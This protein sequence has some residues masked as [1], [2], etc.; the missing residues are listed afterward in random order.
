M[1]ED[2][3]AQR[4]L[5]RLQDLLT[6][7]HEEL[8]TELKDW[9]DLSSESHRAN[10]AQAIL[11]L[12]NHGGGFILLGFTKKDGS[13]APAE[14]RPSD[15]NPYSQDS[16][17]AIVQRYAEPPF[18]C[19]VHHVAHPETGQPFPIV[20]VPG[21]HKIPIRAKR[22]GPNQ[23]HVRQNTYYIRRPGPQSG[24]P[25]SGR[26][27][28][29]L[30]GRC[31][32]A[33]RD[34]LLDRIREILQASG[35]IPRPK[36][37]EEKRSEFENW[38]E[39][40]IARFNSLVAQKLSDE[41]PSRYS[42]GIWHVAYSILGDLRS[43]SL[44]DLLEILRK[45]KG[46]ETGWPPW[47]VPTRAEIAPYPYE[48]VAECWLRETRSDLLFGE[49]RSDNFRFTA[50]SDFWRASPKGMMFLLRGYQED[51]SPH[52][53]PGTIVDV[54]LPIWRTGECLLHAQRLAIALGGRSTSVVIRVTWRGLLGRTLASW[55]NPRRMLLLPESPSRQDS[56]TSEITVSTEQISATLPEIV[57]AL[58]APL[59][60]VFG[61]FVMPSNVIQEELSNM[62]SRVSYTPS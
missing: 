20:V 47:W 26:E 38:I 27:W 33:A 55:A 9:L 32:M 58:T 12:A 56:V 42:K 36:F 22:D 46:H 17:N 21:G 50:D 35:G 6:R 54:T 62:R 57:R 23:E 15:L 34:D 37:A 43:P 24:P 59:Y 19:D 53:E 61:F 10:L 30:I 39:T 45:V 3:Q 5:K 51:G 49:P 13:W 7:A 18:H 4:S 40:S 14:P 16:V 8:D 60:E 11:A 52:T 2:L 41:T 29:E 1:S 48:G 44:P 31:V 25:E 28:D